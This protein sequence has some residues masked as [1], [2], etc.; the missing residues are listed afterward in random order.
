P[1]LL[2]TFV[3]R[4]SNA[5]GNWILLTLTGFFT[6]HLRKLRSKQ[7]V[8]AIMNDRYCKRNIEITVD[9]QERVITFR[10]RGIIIGQF[11]Q[12]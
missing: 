10:Y 5:F 12:R 4:N 6:I 8:V 1:F 11:H 7:V 2:E 9:H 3:G